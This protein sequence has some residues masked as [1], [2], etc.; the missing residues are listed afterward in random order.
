MRRQKG[1]RSSMADYSALEEALRDAL[2]GGAPEKP[3]HPK[4]HKHEV[5]VR[6]SMRESW[7]GQLFVK[8]Y[9][10]ASIS[11]FD[12]HQMAKRD[13]SNNGYIDTMWLETIRT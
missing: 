4:Y 6:Y 3:T 12:A 7:G 8:R 9:T 13:I 10:A 1:P 2:N 11:E 5:T